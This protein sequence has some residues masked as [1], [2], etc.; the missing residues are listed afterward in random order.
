MHVRGRP[1]ARRHAQPS[2]WRARRELERQWLPI[3]VAGGDDELAVDEV[4]VDLKCAAIGRD[5]DVVRPYAVMQRGTLQQS[6]IVEAGARR[7]LPTI[8][9]HSCN[10]VPR[11]LPTR[12]AA[13]S[14]THGPVQSSLLVALND[15][16]RPH[17]A[18][19]WVESCL[20]AGSTL[21]QQIPALVEAHFE[22]LQAGLVALAE[23]VTGGC[24][25][26][27]MVFLVDQRADSIEQVVIHGA[28]TSVRR[29]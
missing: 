13:T 23:S 26:D 27:E 10:G 5:I 3:S 22:V 18:E 1:V 15:L 7:R 17:P 16:G 24:C 25:P 14:A 8:W 20:A 29:S 4:E 9:V 11:R 12:R 6:D 19:A 28:H 21:A 2:I